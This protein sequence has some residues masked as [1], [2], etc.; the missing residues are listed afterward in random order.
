MKNTFEVNH[1]SLVDYRI[2][3][4]IDYALTV[5]NYLCIISRISLISISKVLVLKSV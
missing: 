1:P 2:S 3:Q 5:F 4:F